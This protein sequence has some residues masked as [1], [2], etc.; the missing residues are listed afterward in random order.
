MPNL[1]GT[2]P[3]QVPTNG[4]LGNMAFQNKEGVVVD[5]VKFPDGTVQTTAPIGTVTSVSGTGTVSGLTLTGTVTGAGN[6]TLGGTLSLTSGNVTTALGY[7]PANKAGDTFTGGVTLS[8]TGSH[9]NFYE[10]DAADPADR[11]LIELNANNLN[12]YGF[13]NSDSAF[14]LFMSGNVTTGNVSTNGAW[15]FASTVSVNATQSFSLGGST[16]TYVTL[17][18]NGVSVADFGTANNIISGT[19]GSGFG[20]ATRGAHPIVF[21]IATVEKM[22]IDGNGRVGVNTTAPATLFDI[23]GNMSQN[24]VA[25]AALDIDCSAGNYFTKT[26]NANS[27]FTFSFSPASRA[28]AFTLELVHTSGTVTWPATVR[29]PGGTA[30]TLTTSRTHLFTFVTDDAGANWRAASQINYT[31]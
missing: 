6:L 20:V 22:R 5:R 18:N 8:T 23:N 10:T 7:T 4:S 9:L 3:N 15:S 14:R 11:G 24:I 27:T 25:V 29:W 21:G 12:F 30:P 28:Y 16:G 31:A 2:A 26:I 19:T 17:Q 13:D 1:I